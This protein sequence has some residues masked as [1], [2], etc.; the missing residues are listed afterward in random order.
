[1]GSTLL[2]RR[3]DQWPFREYYIGQRPLRYYPGTT[4]T[5]DGSSF[6][7]STRPDEAAGR[8][9]ACGNNSRGTS[10]IGKAAGRAAAC[11]NSSRDTSNIGRAAGRAAACSSMAPDSTLSRCHSTARP[12]VGRGSCLR[13]GLR[14]RRRPAEQRPSRVSMQTSFR[15]S[16]AGRYHLPSKGT[17]PF[18][19]TQKSGQSPLSL[20]SAGPS[21]AERKNYDSPQIR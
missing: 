8:A 13:P 16:F 9:A 17:V 10:N 2:N 6:R 12:A 14:N 18:L 20:L 3:K 19:L 21:Q 5:D 1:M 11:G 7:D 15:I 4:T